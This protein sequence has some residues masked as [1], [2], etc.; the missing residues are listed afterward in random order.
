MLCKQTR[1]VYSVLVLFFVSYFTQAHSPDFS[2]VIISKTDSGQIVLQINTSLTAFQEEVNYING[3]GAYNTPKA[4]RDLVLKHFYANF[5]IVINNKDTLQFKDP[6]VFLGHET[7]LVTEVLG[8]PDNIKTIQ[9]KNELFKDIHNNQSIVIF[10]LDQFPTTKYTLTQDNNHT[11]YIEYVNGKWHEIKA[12]T[13]TEY[14]NFKY[15]IFIVCIIVFFGL[16][17]IIKKRKEFIFEI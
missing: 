16:V 11:L 14:L 2:N 10:L 15:G 1:T 12:K 4:F 3:T 8:M 5:S 7:K 17:Y 9:L 13:K 6:K